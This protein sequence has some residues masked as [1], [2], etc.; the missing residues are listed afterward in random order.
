[1][2]TNNR[3]KLYLDLNKTK[4]P[5]TAS[6]K[7]NINVIIFTTLS[8]IWCSNLN[9]NSI[10]ISWPPS[11]DSTGNILNIQTDILATASGRK[12]LLQNKYNRKKQ[13]KQIKLT[14]GPKKI[15]SKFCFL[16]LDCLC[17]SEIEISNADIL[18]FSGGVL[19]IAII[20]ICPASCM[21][22]ENKQNT[23]LC[24][25]PI[26]RIIA[27]KHIKKYDNSISVLLV[28]IFICAKNIK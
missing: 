10:Y 26:I 27:I 19:K 2:Q 12:T 18:I 20:K 25:S 23:N 1:M 22:T 4:N 8:H 9:D 3:E 7:I 14:K 21:I 13:I 17:L 28:L 15:I 11:S 6:G 16:L 24:K 5:N